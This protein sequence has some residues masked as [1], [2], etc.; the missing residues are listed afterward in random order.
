MKNKFG[1]SFLVKSFSHYSLQ[2]F[3]LAILGSIVLSGCGG[4][5]DGDKQPKSDSSISQIT[6]ALAEVSSS[7]RGTITASWLPASNDP[8]IASTLTYELHMNTPEG[9][10]IPT[11]QTLRF[12]GKAVLS[13]KVDN[14]Q[15]GE[16]YSVKLVVEDANG[17]RTVGATQSILV[18]GV[19]AAPISGVTVTTISAQQVV[20]AN[21]A[22]G[23]LTL[24]ASV[25]PPVVG[26][27]LVSDVDGGFLLKVVSTQK[28][29][30]G[31]TVV[32]TEPAAINE[33]VSTLDLSS[34]VTLTP[35]PE[36]SATVMAGVVTS[37]SATNGYSMNWPQ[38]GFT[39]SSA[40]PRKVASVGRAVGLVRSSA[41]ASSGTAPAL[42]ISQES[43]TVSGEWGS[44]SV[45]KL[46]G[47]LEGQPSRAQSIDIGINITDSSLEL[48][49]FEIRDDTTGRLAET[50]DKKI[51]LTTE[52]ITPGPYVVTLRA[53][54]DKKG[55]GCNGDDWS[56]VWSEYPEIT[57]DVTVTS[58]NELF[59]Q[60]QKAL[61][62]TGGFNVTNTVDF[63]FDPRLEMEIRMPDAMAIERARF[64]VIANTHLNQT[65][66]IDALGAATLNKQSKRLIEPRK[67]TKVFLVGEI[68]VVIEGVFWL[69]VEVEGHANGKINATEELRLDFDKLSYGLQ[70]SGATD[71]W[72][73]I[74][75]F[76]P[77][78][79]FTVHGDGDAEA[80]VQVALVPQMKVQIYRIPTARLALRPY[81]E[82]ETGLHGQVLLNQ[83]TDGLTT[84]ADAWLTKGRLSGGIDAYL[85]GALEIVNR[86]IISYP[87]EAQPD[88]YTTH[89]KEVLVD[90]TPFVELPTLGTKQI[91]EF[92]PVDSRAILIRAK[93]EDLQSPFRRL[94]APFGP[95]GP[96][97]L[98]PFEGWHSPR[99][100]V[101]NDTGYRWLP[102][103]KGN[104]ESVTDLIHTKDY[105]LVIDKPGIYRVRMGGYSQL[106][107][108]ARQVADDIILTMTDN[109]NDGMLDQWE[110]KYG[111]DNPNV[112]D[113]G[114][115]LTNLQE[116]QQGKNPKSGV[117]VATG[118]GRVTLSW[119]D[120]PGATSY[121]LYWSTTSPVT[122]TDGQEIR[123]ITSPYTQNDLV[124]GETYYY[125]VIALDADGERV[126]MSDTLEAHATPGGWTRL[127]RT[128][129][130]GSSVQSGGLMVDTIGNV[131]VSSFGNGNGSLMV[132]YDAAG[133]QQWT[134]PNI[135]NPSDVMIDTISSQA[136]QAFG[137]Y[138][139]SSDC[140]TSEIPGVERQRLGMVHDASGNAYFIGYYSPPRLDLLML[141]GWG[142]FVAKCDINGVQQWVQQVDTT[143]EG[144]PVLHSMGVDVAGDLYISLSID[145]GMPYDEQLI[146]TE[147]LSWTGKEDFFAKYTATGGLQ[148][149]TKLTTR[150]NPNKMVFNGI[151]ADP[152]GGVYVSGYCNNRESC[153]GI[154]GN[155]LAGS[156]RSFVL[157]YNAAGLVESPSYQIDAAGIDYVTNIAADTMGNVYVVGNNDDWSKQFVTK[158]VI[159]RGSP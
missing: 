124:N 31:S 65:V 121:N 30:D 43:K 137:S 83:N 74:K 152:S 90:T 56:G 100:I 32:T 3:L 108:W 9:D 141:T 156:Q 95:F 64:E 151:V 55:D 20:I 51:Y 23:T 157:K 10:F 69:D 140:I 14:L 135:E 67:F 44:L 131:Y 154:A 120:I 50:L 117:R 57:V 123:G 107:P 45:P 62:F 46:V 139:G 79:N 59:K 35:V 37:R 94:A 126:E 71:T 6:A 8:A 4:S 106:G 104:G 155:I 149:M 93:A 130:S 34:T 81:L 129:G 148:W 102:P 16:R 114:D 24:S 103:A 18:S 122:E 153:G 98:L 7:E 76:Q 125:K 27:I 72:T 68:P 2:Y 1:I 91:D 22:A 52:G 96:E 42:E 158:Y 105:W 13:T 134:R 119:N 41:A 5:V 116:F 26:T 75:T 109:D 92:N 66:N 97:T 159:D 142:Y 89:K 113:D 17:Q 143:L 25:P 60:E 36:S 80:T 133:V 99:V 19:A 78:Y 12:R 38:T 144:G 101:A 58:A 118:E 145:S 29:A 77:R 48:C 70:Y 49:K 111:V 88:D 61:E 147:G 11:D 54:L 84:D 21:P 87:L 110:T 82:A 15:P 33:V 112:D 136:S 138:N 128:E 86:K 40:E 150:S 85:Y 115:G 53:Y 127:V 132:K 146:S 47:V 28:Q 73:P 63:Q 39:L